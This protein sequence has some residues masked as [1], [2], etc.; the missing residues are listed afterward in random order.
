MAIDPEPL[1]GV[2]PGTLEELDLAADPRDRF[3]IL[4][5]AGAV[6]DPGFIFPIMFM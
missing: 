2:D 5:V 1:S 3:E 6:K 4:G